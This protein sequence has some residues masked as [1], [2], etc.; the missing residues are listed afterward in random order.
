MM[1]KK[2]T[3]CDKPL[4]PQARVSAE[5]WHMK[6]R[7]TPKTLRFPPSFAHIQDAPKA[8]KVMANGM[9]G[10]SNIKPNEYSYLVWKTS[11]TQTGGFTPFGYSQ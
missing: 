9:H 7:C 5:D 4:R 2:G 3:D 8:P 1:C 11:K 6:N 10:S